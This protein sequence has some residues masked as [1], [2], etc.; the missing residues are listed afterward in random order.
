MR[1]HILFKKKC[2]FIP[3]KKE[4]TKKI[5]NTQK[6]K[7]NPK[8]HKKQHK[9]TYIPFVAFLIIPNSQISAKEPN[10]KAVTDA[11]YIIFADPKIESNDDFETLNGMS[12]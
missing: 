1:K 8:H 3:H 5:E 9:R 2:N 6:Q 10:K 4:K 11:T 12:R 7:I